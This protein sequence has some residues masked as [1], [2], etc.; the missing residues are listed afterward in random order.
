MKRTTPDLYGFLYDEKAEKANEEHIKELLLAN[1]KK[2]KDYIGKF[3]C[4][5]KKESDTLLKKVFR[6]DTYSKR[7]TVVEIL[8]KMNVTV[9]PYCNRQYIF[10]LKSGNA[11]PQ[12]DHYYPK[13]KYP[14]LALSLYNDVV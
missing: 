14:Y 9:C 4:I 5:S 3:G 6:Y 8:R 2:L 1:R 7:K 10:T 11:R 12:L 13:N